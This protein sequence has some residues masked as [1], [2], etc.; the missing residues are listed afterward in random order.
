MLLNEGGKQGLPRQLCFGFYE[1]RK[2]GLK[3]YGFFLL[4][5]AMWAGCFAVSRVL[6]FYSGTHWKDEMIITLAQAVI[7][8]AFLLFIL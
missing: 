2:R 4:F 7:I 8:S 3:E 6:S 5:L 1:E